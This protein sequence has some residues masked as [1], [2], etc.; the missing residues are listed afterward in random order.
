MI[1][2]NKI[3]ILSLL[4]AIIIALNF[5][6]M[7]RSSGANGWFYHMSIYASFITI[8]PVLLFFVFKTRV[9]YYFVVGFLVFQFISSIVIIGIL[10]SEIEARFQPSSIVGIALLISLRAVVIYF[11]ATCIV[12]QSSSTTK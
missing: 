11:L 2:K 1:I 4:L 9:L 8:L 12:P 6:G 10:H 7:N 3:L 5:S